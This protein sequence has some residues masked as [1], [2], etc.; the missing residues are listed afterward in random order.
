MVFEGFSIVMPSKRSAKP[1]RLVGSRA[2]L[3]VFKG[4][5]GT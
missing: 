3:N 5:L 4:K 1:R 2:I